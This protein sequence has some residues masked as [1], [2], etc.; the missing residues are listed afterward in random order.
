LRDRRE[1]SRDGADN[2]KPT[3]QTFAYNRLT[4]D[5]KFQR[6]PRITMKFR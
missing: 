6:S 3:N 2:L 1:L 5:G 4:I